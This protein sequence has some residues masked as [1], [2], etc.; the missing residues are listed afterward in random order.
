MIDQT[1]FFASV[2]EHP[3]AATMFVGVLA[4]LGVIDWQTGRLPDRIVLPTLW[5]GLVLNACGECFATA[6]DAIL[7]CAAGYGALWLLCALHRC[8]RGSVA[9]GGGDLKLAAMIGAW[10]GIASIPAVLLVAFVSGSCAAAP[11]LLRRKLRLSH[12]VPFG[13]ALALGG[14]VALATGPTLAGW[15]AP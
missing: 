1:L 4:S 7:G 11:A 6:S 8:L 3:V 12:T 14:C 9:F 5:S 13:P 10:L 15:L 2:G